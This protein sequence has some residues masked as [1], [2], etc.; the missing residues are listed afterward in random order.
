MIFGD[1]Y[2][3]VIIVPLSH[4]LAGSVDLLATSID[5]PPENGCKDRCYALSA[6]VAST[7]RSRIVRQTAS[8]ITAE[9]LATIRAQIALCSAVA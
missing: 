5:P 7:S 3:N 2:P 9:Q 4:E 6:H 1:R 8:H